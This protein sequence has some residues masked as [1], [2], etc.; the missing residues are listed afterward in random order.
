[1]ELHLQRGNTFLVEKK[2]RSVPRQGERTEPTHERRVSQPSPL[3]AEGLHVQTSETLI[4]LYR[5]TRQTEAHHRQHSPHLRVLDHGEVTTCAHSIATP[6][7]IADSGLLT[8]AY[9]TCSDA[10]RYRT[11]TGR[12]LEGR[13]TLAKNY[14]KE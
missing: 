14:P 10:S 6:N 5:I 8:P 3:Q 13:Y 9:S 12:R 4:A 1:M 2:R 7:T 11:A